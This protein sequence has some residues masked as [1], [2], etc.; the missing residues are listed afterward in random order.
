MYDERSKLREIS[1][2]SQHHAPEPCPTQKRMCH[3]TMSAPRAHYC[4]NTSL[5][6]SLTNRRVPCVDILRSSTGF[7]TCRQSFRGH[8]IVFLKK[9]QH[10]GSRYSSRFSNKKGKPKFTLISRCLKKPVTKHRVR[11][12]RLS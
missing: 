5:S 1:R 4:S 11:V 10:T 7:I 12:F 8:S 9:I 6:P 2:I 3:I